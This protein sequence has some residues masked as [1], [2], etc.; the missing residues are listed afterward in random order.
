VRVEAGKSVTVDVPIF[1]GFVAVSAPIIVEIAEGGRLLGTSEN[2]VM[3]APGK[4]QLRFTNRALNYEGTQTVDIEPGEVFKLALDPRGTANIN[5]VP[6]AEVWIDGVKAGETP[7]ANLSIALGVREIVFK[8]PQFPDRKL[9]TTVTGGA[10][11][12][13]SVDFTKH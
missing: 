4:H 11:A 2:Q 5:A 1:S 8:N 10:P 13:L 12:A 9:T 6:W 7:I 3:L